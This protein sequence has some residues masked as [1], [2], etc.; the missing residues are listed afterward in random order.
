VIALVLIGGTL[1]PSSSDLLAQAPKKGKAEETPK[2]PEPPR[3]LADRETFDRITLDANNKNAVIEVLPLDLPDRKLPASPKPTD[4]MIIRLLGRPTQQ[5][6]VSWGNIAKVELFE[7]MLLREGMKLTLDKRYEE[8]FE[9]FDKVYRT[10][11][12]Y[13]GLKE[14]IQE[15]LYANARHYFSVKRYPEALSLLEELYRLNPEY[16]P[17]GQQGNLASAI[18]RLIDQFMESYMSSQDYSAARNMMIRVTN[19][20]GERQ[21]ETV[22]KWR[23]QLIELATKHRDAA[24][25]HID[26]SKFREALAESKE[27]MKVWPAVKGGVELSKEISERYPLVIVGVTQRYAGNDFD[28]MD[29]FSARRVGRLLQRKLCEYVGKGPEGGRYES[30]LGTIDSSDDGRQMTLSLR[31]P[32]E[33][34]LTALNGYDV[35]RKLM[36]LADPK[37]PSYSSAWGG[38]MAGVTVE[39]VTRV[40]IDLRRP[41]VLPQ[42]LLQISLPLP[43]GAVGGVAE[44]YVRAEQNDTEA[45]YLVNRQYQFFQA[46]QPKEIV[47]KVYEKSDK[48]IQALKRGDIDLVE[49]IY[50]ADVFRLKNDK[51]VVVGQYAVPTV[52]VLAPN[53]KKQ[54]AANRTFRRGIS[55]SVNREGILDTEIMGGSTL[56]GCVAISGPLPAGNGGSDALAYAYDEKIA[57]RPYQPRLGLTLIKLAGTELALAKQKEEEA[58]AAAKAAAEGKP[59]PNPEA[60]PADQPAGKPG[61]PPPKKP[62]P[63]IKLEKLVIGHPPTEVARI[64]CQAIVTQLEMLHLTVELVE[65]APGKLNDPD[66]VCDFVYTELLISEPVVDMPKM[67]GF[68]G[69]FAESSPYVGLALRR[70]E[71][72]RSWQDSSI[73]LKEMHRILYDDVT[74]IPLWQISEYYAYRPWLRGVGDQIVTLYQ[75]VENW[76]VGLRTGSE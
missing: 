10:D 55:Y 65:L 17:A 48:A 20:Y 52:H 41:H 13:P 58:K 72:A 56:P 15:Y 70:L 39:D 40:I 75:N 43:A 28:R 73:T 16:K 60:P 34:D 50:P 64:A 69:L 37:D 7:E 46:R 2:P 24:R 63:E 12:K 61:D 3:R 27:M 53:Y 11:P 66:G 57:P 18:G 47:E 5:F 59:L 26:N 19:S 38:L 44:P 25:L 31:S 30:P 45:R 29:D 6:E 23:S 67:V 68:R 74:V 51:S 36:S 4:K 33:G 54:F 32:V 22:D 8:A 35:A 62:L 42:S 21:Q 1:A 9:Y 71:A 76:Q 49:R 14:A